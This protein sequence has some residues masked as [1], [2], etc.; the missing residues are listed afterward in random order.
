[1]KGGT[2]T[3]APTQTT[4][5]KTQEPTIDSEDSDVEVNDDEVEVWKRVKLSVE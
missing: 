4:A 1:M 2:I 3:R 5:Q